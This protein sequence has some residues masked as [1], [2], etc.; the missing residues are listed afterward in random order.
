[1]QG[2]GCGQLEPQLSEA[3]RRDLGFLKQPG[4][5][6]V[7]PVPGRRHLA[8]TG[9][10]HQV[11]FGPG[12]GSRVGLSRAGH[13]QHPQNLFALGFRG[14]GGMDIGTVHG[15]APGGM[16]ARGV[17]SVT[18]SRSRSHPLARARRLIT[19]PNGTCN[20]AAISRYERWPK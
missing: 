19:V 2:T 8:A 7:E 14:L 11:T 16:D 4:D 13:V 1:M 17:G 18:V 15:A 9:A 3:R 10:V 20:C 6:P 12:H 5:L